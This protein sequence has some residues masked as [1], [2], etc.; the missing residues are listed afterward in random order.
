MECASRTVVI[1]Q[2]VN[3]VIVAVSGG[4]VP[5]RRFPV[6]PLAEKEIVDTNGA[7]DAFVGGYL[8]K[9]LVNAPVEQCVETALY[10][11]REI[12]KMSGCSL[13]AVNI[14]RSDK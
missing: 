8:A 12:I 2:G 5:I 13:P 14:Y 6:L 11:A 3:D 7:G 10:A 1:T 4:K 9:L